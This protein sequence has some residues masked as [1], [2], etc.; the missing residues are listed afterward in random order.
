[1]ISIL[2]FPEC[3][4]VSVNGV[5]LSDVL[6]RNSPLPQKV[7]GT[8]RLENAV[9]EGDLEDVSLD[10][11]RLE[12]I[13]KE[14]LGFG[15]YEVIHR[16]VIFT[17][18]V[19]LVGP[20]EVTGA[21]GVN[22]YEL[23]GVAEA[24]TANLQNLVQNVLVSDETKAKT[25]GLILDLEKT[26]LSKGVWLDYLEVEADLS[27]FLV[28]GKRRVETFRHPNEK[29]LTMAFHGPTLDTESRLPSGCFCNSIGFLYL[30][31]SV[32]SLGTVDCVNVFDVG[33]ET[34]E[35]SYTIYSHVV[36]YNET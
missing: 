23:G 24:F 7:T 26:Q 20:V 13:A 1:M 30:D 22:N 17:D 3:D 15:R 16:H 33:G 35:R 2:S 34:A 32:T 36:S 12:R 8:K 4:A 6:R 11:I 21:G 31:K 18:T 9:I 19:H 25:T 5:Q 27:G 10:G 29:G 14:L 28:G